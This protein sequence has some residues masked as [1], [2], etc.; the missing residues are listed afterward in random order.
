MKRANPRSFSTM[1][2]TQSPGW[3]NARRSEEHTSELQSRPH[4]VCGLLLEKKGGCVAACVRVFAIG[5]VG[6]SEYVRR[7]RRH[8]LFLF[9]SGCIFIRLWSYPCSDSVRYCTLLFLD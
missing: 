9:D 5:A 4:L 7:P 8:A 1:S 6:A 3:M 2:S